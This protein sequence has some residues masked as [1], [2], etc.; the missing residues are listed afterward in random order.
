MTKHNEPNHTLGTDAQAW[1]S[2]SAFLTDKPLN[3]SPLAL[4]EG[5]P[6]ARLTDHIC[7]VSV[8]GT[9]YRVPGPDSGSSHIPE[10]LYDIGR[11]EGSV[12]GSRTP[13]QRHAALGD[14]SNLWLGRW[15]R[16]SSGVVGYGVCELGRF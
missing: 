15:P 9:G 2:P 1:H 3:P 13:R 11:H 6:G 14:I 7:A 8:K 12:I 16:E 5:D 10:G 4:A